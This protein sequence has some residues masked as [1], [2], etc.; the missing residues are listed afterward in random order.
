MNVCSA[1]I[2][3]IA[4]YIKCD[5]N[6]RRKQANEREIE[7][8]NTKTQTIWLSEAFLHSHVQMCVCKSGSVHV[9]PIDNNNANM[10]KYSFSSLTSPLF[11]VAD[12]IVCRV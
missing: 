1:H 3:G 8:K 5:G 9:T 10:G 12:A 7:W 2:C 6:R 11:V 4:R